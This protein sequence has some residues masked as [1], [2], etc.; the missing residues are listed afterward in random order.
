MAEDKETRPEAL[1]A[2]IYRQLR[3]IREAGEL[4][5]AVV[6]RMDQYRA[7]QKYHASLGETPAPAFDY[8]D[9]YTVL[10]LPV[11]IENSAM[12]GTPR[13]LRASDSH[14]D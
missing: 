14:R 10:G 8:I 12:D 7:I 6:I 5:E 11:L 9:K 13:V 1:L 4:P 3:E 2:E